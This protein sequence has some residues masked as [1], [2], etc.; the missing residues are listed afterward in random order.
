MPGIILLMVTAAADNPRRAGVYIY[1]CPKSQTPVDAR[2]QLVLGCPFL[3]DGARRR[4]A[5]KVS[6]CL[7]WAW[8]IGFR[9]PTASGG[10]GT[11]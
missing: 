10:Q 2:V 4:A 5:R 9:L 11:P 1:G 3:A 6:G 7:P 8:V